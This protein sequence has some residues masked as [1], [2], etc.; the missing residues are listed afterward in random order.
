MIGTDS[1]MAVV[2]EEEIAALAEAVAADYFSSGPFAI[3][4]ILR[5]CDLTISFGHYRNAFDGMLEHK[6]SR[7]HI[8]C[9][10][11][12][13]QGENSPRARFTLGHEL[14]HYFIDEHRN[15]LSSGKAPAHPSRCEYESMLLVERE[16]DHFAS[17]LLMPTAAFRKRARAHKPGFAG[18][19]SIA[20]FF[21]VSV[22]SAA[23]RY[24]KEEIVPCA[25]LKWDTNGKFQWRWISTETFKNRLRKA[26]TDATKLP[27][28]CPTRRA[29]AGE[30][31]PAPG[32]LEAGTTAAAW[33][34]A[35]HHDAYRNAI[36]IEQAIALGRFGILTFLFPH[37][38]QFF[39]P[40]P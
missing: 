25:V 12:R 30:K 22:T 33:F 18:I 37:D 27:S 26:F 34:P 31:A 19:L 21:G 35:V 5:D 2:R 15:A 16:A 29:M 3:E 36:F 23:L 11:D 32:F 14:G 4:P 10:L 9:N 6:N 17:H 40:G 7:F 38:R 8:Y 28:D 24:A 20:D 13:V 39:S 1:M